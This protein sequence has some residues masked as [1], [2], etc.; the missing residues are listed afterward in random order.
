MEPDEQG[1]STMVIDW[2]CKQNPDERRPMSKVMSLD[3]ILNAAVNGSFLHRSDKIIF[4]FEEDHS[5]CS[6]ENVWEFPGSLVV[7]T[8]TVRGLG[9]IPGRGTKILQAA[10]HGQKKN[11]IRQK[12]RDSER[13]YER[14]QV[15]KRKEQLGDL[16]RG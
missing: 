10:W 5:S 12:K 6:L 11:K 9:S 4:P 16:Y 2:R 8:L 3:F 15:Q 13:M 14:G 1:E 7:R